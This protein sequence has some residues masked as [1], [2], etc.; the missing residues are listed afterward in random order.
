MG[1]TANL[2]LQLP[3][4]GDQNWGDTLNAN[5]NLIDSAVGG[6]T[7]K[8]NS[9]TSGGGTSSSGGTTSSLLTS[10]FGRTGAVTAQNGD[11]TFSQISGTVLTS[12]GGTG[13]STP[14]GARSNL[15]AAAAGTNSDILALNGLNSLKLTGS[16]AITGVQGTT[17]TALVVSTGSFTSGNLVAIDA[18]GNVI[19]AN[20][21]ASAVASVA[22]TA[23]T[24]L[25]TA[26]AAQPQSAKGQPNGYVG[27]DGTGGI[28]VVSA[29]VSNAGLVIPDTI[30]GHT[31]RLQFVNG[32]LQ[33]TQVS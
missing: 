13:A 27:L 4:D 2:G 26:N 32:S 9:V 6:L 18:N 33:A 25:T 21:A 8:V 17:G 29:T 23:S 20:V 19:D 11:Y 14:S 12:Q 30:N 10:V 15:G 3:A 7:A 28:T 5:L 16:Q 1:Q 31:Y 24:A 22:S